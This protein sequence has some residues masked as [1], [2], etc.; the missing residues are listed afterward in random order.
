MLDIKD[1]SILIVP[2]SIKES[3]IKDIRT[4]GLYNIKFMTLE[5]I[6]HRLYF[7]YNKET[8]YY[9]INIIINMM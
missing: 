2:N 9:L 7:D 5:E 6:I 1:N 4:K 3:I 8:I